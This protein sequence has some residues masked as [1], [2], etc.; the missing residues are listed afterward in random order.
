MSVDGMPENCARRSSRRGRPDRGCVARPTCWSLNRLLLRV[1]PTRTGSRPLHLA[2]KSLFC[3]ILPLSPLRAIFCE[4]SFHL[5]LCF[6][7]FAMIGGEGGALD[8]HRK[9]FPPHIRYS[10]SDTVALLVPVILLFM[11]LQVM[12]QQ[13]VA[14]QMLNPPH[15]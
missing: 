4:E 11:T 15:A 3:N 6:Q 13:A 8:P 12:T 14:Q 7:Y 2:V 9:R 10:E 5:S 1:F